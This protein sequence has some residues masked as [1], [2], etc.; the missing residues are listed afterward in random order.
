MEGSKSGKTVQRAG[1]EKKPEYVV[2]SGL[3]CG[4]GLYFNHQLCPLTLPHF[5]HVLE[6]DEVLWHHCSN[7]TGEKRYSSWKMINSQKKP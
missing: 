1:D 7:R 3:L 5:V 4:L 2:E 6:L